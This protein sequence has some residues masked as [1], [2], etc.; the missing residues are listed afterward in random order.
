MSKHLG[1]VLD[2]LETIAQVGADPLRWFFLTSVNIG[3]PY[4][5]SV[6]VLKETIRRF[7]LILWNCLSFFVTYAN[8]N[9]WSPTKTGQAAPFGDLLDRWIIAKSH[10]LVEK[11]TTNMEAFDFPAAGRAIQDF[12]V[13]DLS[14]WYIRCSRNRVGP[15]ADPADA[16]ACHRTLYQA[17]KTLSLLLAPL[18]PFLAEIIH[19]IL[20][21]RVEPSSVH[22]LSWPKKGRVDRKLIELMSK[23]RKVVEVGLRQRKEKGIRLRQPLALA[24]LTGVGKWPPALEEIVAKELNVKKIEIVA[25]PR[26]FSVSLD[27]KLTKELKEEGL[28]REVIRLIQDLRKKAGY[29]FDEQIILEIKAPLSLKKVFERFGWEIEKATWTKRG[30]L[31]KVDQ[32][33]ELSGARVKVGR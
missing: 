23:A 18:T 22:L 26:R 31:K 3:T 25:Q 5:V 4:R 29:R 15:G 9:Q 14:T 13:G 33:G 21:E 28:V 27:V 12:V 32:E 16:A 1:N 30:K 24:T 11:V 8:L 6:E 2:P 17:L 19:Q 20:R 10:E 7:F